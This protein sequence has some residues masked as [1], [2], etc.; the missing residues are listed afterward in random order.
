M[1]AGLFKIFDEII[2]TMISTEE[3][4][5]PHPESVRIY[6]ELYRNIY[7]KTYLRPVLLC[8][9]GAEITGY[10]EN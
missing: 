1:A 5:Q 10:K 7:L 4:F 8:R 3:K 6:K 9:W 2:S